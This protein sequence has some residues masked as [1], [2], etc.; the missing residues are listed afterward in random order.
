MTSPKYLTRRAK[1]VFQA[2]H[3]ALVA[4]GV[5]DDTDIDLLA[6]YAQC[7]ADY[8]KAT[9]T[10]EK[11][12]MIY[13]DGNNQKRKHP[14]IIAQRGYAEQAA[15]LAKQL[16]IGVEG[17]K[18]IKQEEKERPVSKLALLQRKKIG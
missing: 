9:A 6:A 16:G 7:I 13:T 4:R 2:N 18:K 3:R 5:W 14:L 1:A 12:G 8:E 17:R 11:E 10:I 15:K